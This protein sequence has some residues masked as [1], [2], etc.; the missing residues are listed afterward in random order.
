MGA[1]DGGPAFPGEYYSPE[2]FRD[3]YPTE[4]GHEATK[5]ASGKSA[6]MSLR[7]WFA[8]SAP[9]PSE[10]DIQFERDMDREACLEEYEAGRI[11]H[12]GHGPIRSRASII[13][14]LAFRHADA[15]LAAREAP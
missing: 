5:R 6:G 8:A 9:I 14:D 4:G 15:M 12:P 11:K 2:V 1:K 13:A 7:D 3:L 10:F